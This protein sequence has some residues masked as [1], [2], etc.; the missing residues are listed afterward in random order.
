MTSCRFS[1]L[2]L[3]EGLQENIFY[4]CGNFVFVD[5]EAVKGIVDERVG[6]NG[7]FESS[8]EIDACPFNL[9]PINFRIYFP[10]IRLSLQ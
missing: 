6:I 1:D 10:L 8:E 9:N 4:A 7:V 3:F 2:F 5:D